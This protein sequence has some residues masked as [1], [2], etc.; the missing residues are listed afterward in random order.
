MA[1]ELCPYCGHAYPPGREAS[2]E[3]IGAHLKEC[4]G[5]QDQPADWL[6][7]PWPVLAPPS[8]EVQAIL[9][10][11]DDSPLR[12]EARKALARREAGQATAVSEPLTEVAPLLGTCEMCDETGPLSS[13]RVCVNRGPCNDRWDAMHAWRP[14]MLARKIRRA[15]SR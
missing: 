2:G 15:W 1:G 10:E 6:A 7:R 4:P 14:V 13:E 12:R 9:R 5:P 3:E 8:P 11:H